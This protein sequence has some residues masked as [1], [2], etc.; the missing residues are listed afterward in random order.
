MADAGAA[1]RHADLAAHLLS[2]SECRRLSDALGEGELA[3]VDEDAALFA[4]GILARTSAADALAAELPAL[5]E[6]DPGPGFT[7]RVLLHTSNRPAP[8][9]WHAQWVAAWRTLARRPRFAW[10][11][12]YVATLCW[13]LVFGNPLSA[14]EWGPGKVSSAAQQRLGWAASDIRQGLEA[15]RAALAPDVPEAASTPG[16]GAAGASDTQGPAEAAWQSAS[17]WVRGR[18]AEVIGALADMWRSVAG[19]FEDGGTASPAAP[20]T[21]PRGEAAR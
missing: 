6:M 12:A 4:D 10:E 16:T 14:W 7:E 1:L 5:A 2:C 13:V 9:R 8:E 11:V 19:W 15:W 3:W 17:N 18:L 21:E 20:A